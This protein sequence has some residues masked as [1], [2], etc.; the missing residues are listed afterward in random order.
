MSIS[1]RRFVRRLPLVVGTAVP[2]GSDL[3]AV[4][5]AGSAGEVFVLTATAAQPYRVAEVLPLKSGQVLYSSTGAVIKGSRIETGWT[6]DGSNPLWYKEIALQD[7]ANGDVQSNM[8]GYAYR[9]PGEVDQAVK[10]QDTFCDGVQLQRYMQKSNLQ[11]GGFYHD[12]S[13]NRTWLADDPSG[14]TIEIA[15]TEEAIH[16]QSSVENCVLDGITICHFASRPQMAAVYVEARGWNI[17]NCDF[18]YNHSMGLK[19]AY[20]TS[21]IMQQNSFHHNGQMGAGQYRCSGTIMSDNEFAYNNYMGDYYALDWESGSIKYAVCNDC[22]FARNYSHHNSGVGLWADIDNVG[23]V[24]DDNIIED[25]ESCGIRHE[26]SFGA[27]ISNNII[28]RNGYGATNGKWR[29]KDPAVSGQGDY[30]ARNGS[31]FMT[32]GI[33]INCS[34]GWQG[35][36]IATIEVFGNTVAYNQNGLFLQ[37]RNRGSSLMYPARPQLVQNVIAHDNT[38]TVAQRV[39]DD[40]G[41]NLSGLGAYEEPPAGSRHDFFY[42]WGNVLRDNTYYVDSLSA[43]RF[44]GSDGAMGWDR[45]DF[46][47]YQAHGFDVGSTCQ[48]L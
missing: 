6:K 30:F 33:N 17:K 48:L 42:N 23:L 21:G 20:I 37:Q 15:I 46:A 43:V 1:A 45:Y 41:D 14:H 9:T 44:S 26:I 18:S 7:Y 28:R 19:L 5:A 3:V 12:Y 34:G 4:L 31:P 2:A 40:W 35:D 22:T 13:A 11:S 10:L 16:A 38:V 8:T 32:A 24:F 27:V 29:T 36:S 25:N 39:G 47:T